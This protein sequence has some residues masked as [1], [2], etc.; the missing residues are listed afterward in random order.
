MAIMLQNDHFE[1][2][3]DLGQSLLFAG[4]ND[5]SVSRSILSEIEKNTTIIYVQLQ[6]YLNSTK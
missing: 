6:H 2:K 4:Y 3:T 1:K 5:G